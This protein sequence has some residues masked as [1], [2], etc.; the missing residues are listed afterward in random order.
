MKK[1]TIII[2]FAAALCALTSCSKEVASLPDM[3]VSPADNTS[4]VAISAGTELAAKAESS[5]V[6]TT[7]A[8]LEATTAATTAS[9]AISEDVQAPAVSETV[10]NNATVYNGFKS[11]TVNG[12]VYTS[13]YAGIKITLPE[14]ANFLDVDNLHT[15][16]IMPTRFMSEDEKSF[17]MTGELDA[18][19][20]YGDAVNRVDVWFYNTKQRYPD[21]PDMSA[22]EFLKADEMDF[23]PEVDVTDI[24]G[25]E[26]VSICGKDYAK[27][28]YNAFSQAHI[29]YARRINDDYI[30]E[31]RTSGF[32]AEDFESCIEAF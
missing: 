28:S 17:Y 26:S 24:V 23:S 6:T 29:T 27:V 8:L 2:T 22:E 12:N 3:A 1:N 31:I 14:D 30:M 20:C 10:Q 7:A 19:V 15:H 13:E 32:T 5:P 16:Y 4:A 11:S 25:P 9:E 18:S 21:N